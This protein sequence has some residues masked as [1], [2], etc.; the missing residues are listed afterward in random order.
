MRCVCKINFH[1]HCVQS[2]GLLSADILRM[3]QTTSIFH[4]ICKTCKANVSHIATPGELELRAKILK[5]EADTP[6]QVHAANTL[7]DAAEL[8]KI[9]LKKTVQDL[10][11]KIDTLQSTPDNSATLT[12]NREL[13]SENKKLNAALSKYQEMEEELTSLKEL[14]DKIPEFKAE[15]DRVVAERN[16]RDIALARYSAH[17]KELD[18]ANIVKDLRLEINNRAALQPQQPIASTSQQAGQNGK[19]PTL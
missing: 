12:R 2:V 5:I 16:E 15:Y 11:R 4:F 19:T 8:E 18:E 14:T 13:S 7:A 1:D 10:N 3:K 9:T 17:L 6:V